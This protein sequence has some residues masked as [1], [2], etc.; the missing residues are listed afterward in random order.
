MP[1]ALRTYVCFAPIAFS[2]FCTDDTPRESS[3]EGQRDSYED[4]IITM[5]R[6]S[7]VDEEANVR[8]AAA[9]A[10]DIL[11]EFIGVKAI[12]ATI[13]TLLEALRQPGQSSGTALQAL[14]EVMSVSHIQISG[15]SRNSDESQVRASTVFPVLIPTLTAIPMSVFNARALASLVTVAGDALSKRLTPIM[16]AVTKAMEDGGEDELVNAVDEAIEA[17]MGAIE[18]AEGLNT[19]MM[20]LLGW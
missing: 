13:P 18:D 10:F 20:I 19:S 5:V 15:F 14:R 3:S 7:L 9:K 8:A 1:H 11:Q 16:N 4:E 12:D 2:A 6:V 17:L